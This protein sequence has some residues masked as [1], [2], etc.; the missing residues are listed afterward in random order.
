MDIRALT[1]KTAP[2][3]AALEAIARQGFSDPA[4]ALVNLRLMAEGVEGDTELGTLY[5][6]LLACSTSSDPDACLNNFERGSSNSTSREGFLGLLAGH[7]GSVKLLAPL[8]AGSAFL[9]R[10]ASAEPEETLGWLLAPG[11]LAQP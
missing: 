1:D 6:A 11:R 9:S 10:F 7:P 5:E 8:F 4:K 3:G 2:Q